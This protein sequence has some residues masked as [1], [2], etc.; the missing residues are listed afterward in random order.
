MRDR[1][2]LS[3]SVDQHFGMQPVQHFLDAAQLPKPVQ[4]G[5]VRLQND[6]EIQIAAPGVRPAGPR[7]EEDGLQD[8][9][10]CGRT[11]VIGF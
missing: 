3:R 5:A 9:P 4:E 7:A 10:L 1:L 11:A 2:E 6:R 8:V